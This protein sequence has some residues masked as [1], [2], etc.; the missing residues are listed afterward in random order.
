M[1]TKIPLSSIRYAYF[2]MDGTI[3]TSHGLLPTQNLQAILRLQKAGVKIG[4]ATG[5]PHYLINQVTN[6]I[7]LDLPVINNDGTEIY[8][9]KSQKSELI[10][11]IN[12]QALKAL[13]TYFF[14]N[15]LGFKAYNTNSIYAYMPNGPVEHKGNPDSANYPKIILN[16]LNDLIKLEIVKMMT[17]MWDFQEFQKVW[18]V[19]EKIPNIFLRNSDNFLLD[20]TP[21][22]TSKGNALKVL[23]DRKIISLDQ[24]LAFGDNENDRL[25]IQL[26]KYGVIMEN[27]T[28]VLKQNAKYLAKPC[29]EFGVA[30]FINEIIDFT[31]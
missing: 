1:S 22:W 18:K 12:P 15:K 27:A 26:A 28:D 6:A 20:V 4:I 19:F 14:E 7:N 3:L 17:I 16:N 30:Q 24:L 21:D 29:A 25:M 11:K 5:R 9:L 23:Q 31:C 8:D 10:G 13:G 2:D